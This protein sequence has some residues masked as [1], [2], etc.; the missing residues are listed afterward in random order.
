METPAKYYQG[1]PTITPR[2]EVPSNK[3]LADSVK[4]GTN[5]FGNFASSYKIR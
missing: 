2:Q 1:Q 5:I 3:Y 4:K